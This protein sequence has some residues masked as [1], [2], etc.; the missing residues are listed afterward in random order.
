[1]AMSMDLSEVI[2][3]D[4]AKTEAVKGGVVTGPL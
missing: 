2:K 3:V 4:V 1:M